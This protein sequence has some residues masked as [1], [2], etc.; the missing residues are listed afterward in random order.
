MRFAVD[1][2]K[3]KIMFNSRNDGARR[4]DKVC[5]YHVGQYVGRACGS[6]HAESKSLRWPLSRHG[7]VNAQLTELGWEHF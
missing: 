5:R 6:L 2:N 4:I 7:V 3:C 1:V